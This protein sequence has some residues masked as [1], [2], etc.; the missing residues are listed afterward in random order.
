MAIII[1]NCNKV[2]QSTISIHSYS[3]IINQPQNFLNNHHRKVKSLLLGNSGLQ[4]IA[5]LRNA[6]IYYLS[7][8][9][10]FSCKLLAA[11]CIRQLSEPS[12]NS[13][14]FRRNLNVPIDREGTFSLGVIVAS[15]P[16]HYLPKN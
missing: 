3:A 8:T 16:D 6:K 15:L 1:S 13:Q 9:K 2:R 7:I 5:Y 14:F 4:L 11:A 12:S 10:Y